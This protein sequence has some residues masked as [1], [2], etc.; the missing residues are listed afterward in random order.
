MTG[1]WLCGAPPSAQMREDTQEPLAVAY[2]SL[3]RFKAQPD[4]ATPFADLVVDSGKLYGTTYQGGGAGFGSVFDVTTAGKEHVIYSFKAGAD[5]AYPC[6]G[7]VRVKGKFYGTTQAGGN[8]NWGTIFEVTPSGHERV[9]YAFKAG[10]DGAAPYAGLLDYKGKL[11]GTTVEGGAKGWGTAF[12]SSTSG[13]ERVLYSFKAGTHDGG[14]PYGTLT[15]LDNTLFGTT[16]EGGAFGWGTVFAVNP[17]SGKE[18]VVYSFKADN[19]GTNDGGYPFGGLANL[20]G[21]LYGT[22]KLGGTAGYGTVFN[23]TS[24]GEEHVMHSFKAGSDGAYPYSRLLVSNDALYG[25]TYQGGPK[26]WGTVFKVATSGNETVLYRFKAG[27]DG[28]WPFDGLAALGGKLYGTASGG[29]AKVGS[30][31]W[32]TIFSVTP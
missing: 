22:T 18:R 11:Y 6:A 14:Y 2:K 8:A 19:K 30:R 16:Q 15:V 26:N 13:K 23:V 9:I 25:A 28:A 27:I 17:A 21:K 24:S 29:G 3:Y 7:L 4:G 32:G 12:E 31:A 5:G 20:N 1:P 10:K